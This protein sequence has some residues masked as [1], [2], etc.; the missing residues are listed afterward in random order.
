M[1]QHK[2][3]VDILKHESLIYRYLVN[4][5]VLVVCLEIVGLKSVKR[6]Q[7]SMRNYNSIDHKCANMQ[8]PRH[9]ELLLRGFLP[10][11][12]GKDIWM[13][14]SSANSKEETPTNSIN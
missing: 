1:I 13:K 4:V 2:L 3:N 12:V 14:H 5:T 6:A 9:L 8:P 7:L 11:T 10:T